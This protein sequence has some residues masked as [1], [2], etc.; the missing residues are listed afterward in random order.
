MLMALH[1]GGWMA[2]PGIAVLPS[3]HADTNGKMLPV[4][5]LAPQL[6]ARLPGAAV[7]KVAG[8]A[9]PPSRAAPGL[10]LTLA[11]AMLPRPCLH[12]PPTPA[13]PPPHH[14]PPLT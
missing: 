4:G 7:V 6:A 14:Q 1:C 3:P 13:T 9:A 10:K 12:E 2:V 11:T 8:A 5:E